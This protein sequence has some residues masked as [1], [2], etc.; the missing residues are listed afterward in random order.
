MKMYRMM[1]ITRL[2]INIVW[3]T[4]FIY[5]MLVLV[6]TNGFFL[7]FEDDG[8][9]VVKSALIDSN[10]EPSSS[11]TS[12]MA[13]CTYSVMGNNNYYTQVQCS[14]CVNIPLHHDFF[15]LC[16]VKVRNRIPLVKAPLIVTFSYIPSTFARMVSGLS[17]QPLIDNNSPLAFIR[18]VILLI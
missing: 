3:C 5:C 17:L 16:L 9:I 13:S 2:K 7:C 18:S 1:N 15:N 6:E 11:A 8:H 14:S 10:C 12:Q 4:V